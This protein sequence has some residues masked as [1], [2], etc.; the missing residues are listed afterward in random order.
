MDVH[1]VKDG[2]RF[3]RGSDLL[4]FANDLSMILIRPDGMT[5][6]QQQPIWGWALITFWIVPATSPPSASA[7]KRDGPKQ[8]IAPF[9]GWK[10]H[11]NF[12]MSALARLHPGADQDSAEKR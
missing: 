2:S 9:Q 1:P 11:V 4:G 8:Q 3:D 12:M 7:T 10:C 5:L 6:P